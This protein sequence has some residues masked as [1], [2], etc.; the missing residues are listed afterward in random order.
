MAVPARALA[1]V[2]PAPRTPQAELGC[3]QKVLFHRPL[4]PCWQGCA[5][6]GLITNGAGMVPHIL[7]IAVTAVC[8][9]SGCA[10]ITCS[11]RFYSQKSFFKQVDILHWLGLNSGIYLLDPTV[12]S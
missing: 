3:R 5:P 9:F 2:H 4:M 11:V 1:A 6:A 7:E 10:R 12:G 8:Y